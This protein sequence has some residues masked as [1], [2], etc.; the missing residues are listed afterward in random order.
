MRISI[1]IICYEFHHPC[2]QVYSRSLP[3]P[4]RHNSI[5][6]LSQNIRKYV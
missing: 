2:Y 6:F 4:I 3:F 1:S 5:F